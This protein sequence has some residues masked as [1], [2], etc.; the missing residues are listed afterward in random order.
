MDDVFVAVVV[1]G[2]VCLIAFVALTY[3]SRELTS[4]KTKALSAQADV[5]AATIVPEGMHPHN[6][7]GRVVFKSIE[8][9]EP[10]V[11]DASAVLDECRLAES[12]L[13]KA[14]DDA[15][16]CHYQLPPEIVTLA[17]ELNKVRMNLTTDMVSKAAKQKIAA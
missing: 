12:H 17:D 6:V 11:I 16:E 13:R 2:G 3:L 10:K 8:R 14:V 7:G 4:W 1:G 5:A 15:V 9:H